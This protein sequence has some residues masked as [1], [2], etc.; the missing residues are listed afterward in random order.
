MLQTHRFIGKFPL[1]II[2]MTPG[3]GEETSEDDRISALTKH[4][5]GDW[6]EVCRED[7]ESNDEALKDGCRLLSSYTSSNGVKFWIITEA[8]RSAT[9]FLLPEEY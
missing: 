5:N 4:H 7:W 1:G 6:G 9:T 3:V 2:Y 8:D